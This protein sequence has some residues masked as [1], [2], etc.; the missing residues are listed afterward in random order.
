MKLQTDKKCIIIGNGKAPLKSV[1]RF[2]KTKNYKT[3]ICADG[4][5]NSARLLNIIPDYIIGDLDSITEE[6]KIFYQN[7]SEVIK[8]K[9]QNDTDVEKCIKFSIQKGYKECILLG[10]IGDRLDHSF[11]NL[12]ISL[13]FSDMI[14]IRIISDKS[15]LSIA[16]KEIR[17]KTVPH[18]IFSIY[19]FDEK[20]TITS[21][22]LKYK[23]KNTVL[24]F[25]KR[26][27]TSNAA[28]KNEVYLK[29]TGGKIFIIRDFETVKKHDLF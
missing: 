14:T 25:G 9:R 26:E 16:E 5:A 27:S 20:T 10:V 24:P 13:K 19:A 17:L 1:I 8:I 11:C 15:I 3:I 29:I 18:E 7:R 6:N 2:L 28:I 22:G 21:Q 12:G 23:L 4:G